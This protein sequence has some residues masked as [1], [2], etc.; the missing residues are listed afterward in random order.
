[1]QRYPSA[2]SSMTASGGVQ[3]CVCRLMIALW[4]IQLGLPFTPHPLSPSPEGEG[5]G[6][7][8]K[9]K[10][11]LPTP[12]STL[13]EGGWGGEV[14][15]AG[16]GLPVLLAVAL[17][18]A[19][20]ADATITASSIG[21]R[22]TP[23]FNTGTASTNAT[24]DTVTFIGTIP[25][26]VGEG[27]SVIIG[28]G[29]ALV[30]KPVSTTKIKLQP[31]GTIGTNLS[32]QAF[33]IKRAQGS[34]AQWINLC[35]ANLV[36]ATKIW[37]AVYYR[38]QPTYDDSVKIMGKTTSAQY[39]VWI[40]AAPQARHTGKANTGVRIVK[41]NTGTTGIILNNA[42][43][44]RIEWLELARTQITAPVIV[45]DS[46]APQDSVVLSNLIIEGGQTGIKIFSTTSK[47]IMYNI[48]GYGAQ[49]EIVYTSSNTAASVLYNS[50]LF[51]NNSGYC[52]SGVKAV[53]VLA[54]STWNQCFTLPVAGSGNNIS[55]DGT[56]PGSFSKTNVQFPMLNF[57]DT[58]T[59]NRDL[60]IRNGSVAIN[61]GTDLSVLFMHDIEG[62]PRAGA[63]DIGADEYPY[64]M[65]F[66]P[67]THTY[68]IGTLADINVTVSSVTGSGPWTVSFS[69]SPSLSRI[70]PGDRFSDGSIHQAVWT[71]TAVDDG[72]D[73]ITVTNSS[74]DT[75]NYPSPF[76]GNLGQ[77]RVGRWFQKINDWA[78]SRSGDLVTGQ[79][80]EKGVCYN[81]GIMD[82]TLHLAGSTTNASYHFWL[83]TAPG[84]RHNGIAG[85]GF[86]VRPTCTLPAN[87]AI[88]TSEVA[89]T[90]IENL[91]VDGSGI[92][93]GSSVNMIKILTSSEGCIVR[94]NL[95]HSFSAGVT[96]PSAG[97]YLGGVGN[98]VYAYNN[99]VRDLDTWAAVPYISG[100][101]GTYKFVFNNTALNLSN[102]GSVAYNMNGADSC[103]NNIAANYS[104]TGF[105]N[106]GGGYVGYNISTDGS[107][108]G[109]NSLTGRTPPSLFMA[110]TFDAHLNGNSPA[111]NAGTNLSGYFTRDIDDTL[112]QYGA[113]DVG[114]DEYV[115]G[116]TYWTNTGGDFSW[117]NPL[118]WST[119]FVPG[120]HDTTVFDNAHSSANCSVDQDVTVAKLILSN[121]YNGNFD[122]GTWN[123]SVTAGIDIRSNAGVAA[124]NATLKFITSDGQNF[125][126][127]TGVQFA[128][129]YTE[130]GGGFQVMANGFSAGSLY[131]NSG[132]ISLGSG[133]V[134]SIGGFSASA[135]TS[136][137]FES[138]T[139]K[140]GGATLDLNSVDDVFPQTGILEFKNISPATFTPK[141]NAN[142]VIVVNTG[143]AMV[144]VAN[145]P[146]NTPKIIV[147]NGTLHLDTAFIADSVFVQAGATFEQG[148]GNYSDT[149]KSIEG[150]G[151]VDMGFADFNVTGNLDL[152]GFNSFIGSG[153]IRFVGA[154]AQN[155]VPKANTMYPAI[156]QDGSGGTTVI[157]NGLHTQGL[158]I[159][160]GAFNIG[161]ALVDSV[162]STLTGAGGGTLDFGTSVLRTAA[163]SVDLSAIG[164][165]SGSSGSIEFVGGGTQ[166]FTAKEGQMN[167]GLAAFYG[168]TL[169]IANKHLR[170]KKVSAYGSWLEFDTTT[171]VDTVYLDNS[172]SITFGTSSTKNDTVK[173]ITGTG[174]L[175]FG[176]GHV[177][178]AGDM[179]DLTP[180]TNVM[181]LGSLRMRGGLSQVIKPN[182][183][184]ALDSVIID[185]AGGVTVET[186][187]LKCNSL[188]LLTGA[189]N[190][191][192]GLTDSVG[193]F[194]SAVAGSELD[195]NSATLKTAAPTLD[196]SALDVLVAGTGT[197]EFCGT[198]QGFIPKDGP[199]HPGII[200][201]NGS[202]VTCSTNAL[203][204]KNLNVSSGNFVFYG[205]GLTHAFDTLTGTASGSLDF[206]GANVA[207]KGDANFGSL[208][209]IFGS[210]NTDTL[211]FIRTSGTQ[212]LTP[213][214]SG[215]LPCIVHANAGTLKLLANN[216]STYG[217]LN[218]GGP[219]DIGTSN[220][221]STG[222]LSIL[223]GSPTLLS[224]I[225]G[226]TLSANN[227][228]TLSGTPGNL[229]NLNPTSTWYAT[230]T[231]G[232]LNAS[233]ATIGYSDA[234]GGSRGAAVTACTNDGNNTHWGIATTVTSPSGS[235]NT[236][237]NP[238]KVTG[239]YTA[240]TTPSD[241]EVRL[242]NGTGYWNGTDWSGNS[243]SW[244]SLTPYGSFSTNNWEMNS[245]VPAWQN[246]T[247][248]TVTSR[249]IEG[250]YVETP[251]AGATFDYTGPTATLTSPTGLQGTGPS[252]ISGTYTGNATDVEVE[253]YN[254]SQYYT[255]G[256]W[257]A[258]TWLSASGNGSVTGY[259][260]NMNAGLPTWISG[261]TY[262]IRCRAKDNGFVEAVPDSDGFVYDAT[263]PSVNAGTD[264]AHNAQFNLAGGSSDGNGIASNAWTKISGA[265]NVTFGDAAS[266]TSTCQM[267]ADDVYVLRLTSID[268]ASNS[269]FDEVQITWDAT[270]PS[271]GSGTEAAHNA[272]F[273]LAGTASD[274]GSG[275]ASTTWIKLSGTGNVTFGN[276][277]S[278]TSSCQMDADDIYV[279]QLSATD[280]AGN[281][282]TG[283]LQVTW[284]ATA[285]SVSSGSTSTYNAPFNLTG[286]ASDAGSGLASTTW[287]KLSGSGNVTFGN[288]A[289][290]TST[291]Q[292][293]ADGIYVLQLSA[294]D[295]AGNSA[296]STVQIT[297]DGAAPI[298]NAGAD[299]TYNALFGLT[300]A[301][302]DAGSGI[303]SNAW[304]KFS[305]PGTVTFG[306]AASLTSSCSMD[307]DGIY[308][309]RLTATDNSA[310][311]AND[312]VQITWDATAPSVSSG[313]NALHNAQ[314]NLAG[315]ATDAV[316]GLSSTTWSK[317]SGSGNVTFGNT[318][319]LTSTCQ[320]DADDIYVLQ[321]SATDVAGNTATSTLQ[322]TWDA[323]NPTGSAGADAPQSAL[324]NLSGSASDV[325][326]GI[327]ST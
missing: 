90:I 35:P 276:T 270:A 131:H 199:A 211:N 61:A 146:L 127:K 28:A 224:D 176:N 105:I 34:M 134:D 245:S 14:K 21:Q 88:I 315:T 99:I 3:K 230:V 213:P 115:Y 133:V 206:A 279:L 283:T 149:L 217:F 37:K 155:L 273:N 78:K 119:G 181:Q 280:V 130:N 156:E 306:N 247:N 40:T 69:G 126:G 299:G 327:A 160:S 114:A 59:G 150:A 139:L 17:F 41:N 190:L 208:A 185:N 223:N 198:S 58:A 240:A 31:G 187:G 170:A 79:R 60:R 222:S 33:T 106:S 63:F 74:Y 295:I 50:T 201:S 70:F 98:K 46:G 95:V 243:S 204:G 143:G 116:N 65:K 242:Y 77:A 13:R 235:I 271:V 236:Y 261:T 313:S 258:Q 42:P 136:L 86:H 298:V 87:G 274:A 2:L 234:S 140:F 278:T 255:G 296:S 218:D 256:G 62:M 67:G 151:S 173:S 112:R 108:S 5:A 44:T 124:T 260:W 301:S 123:F 164:T 138:A 194:F 183:G 144:T 250:G 64:F 81:D 55:N 249:S 319:S 92:T 225:S 159:T 253:I 209:N 200:V 20:E 107:A 322:V 264:A 212:N 48:I 93:A 323:T 203:Q 228:M 72:L 238:N 68:N 104:G 49:N 166:T 177:C 263:G 275:L 94:N 324:F 111:I 43:F 310:N 266:L 314:F 101:A 84:E 180:F 100:D 145:Q 191:G 52:A 268:N 15:G 311:P 246:G 83:T 30:E 244:L 24:A 129:I 289:S 23:L 57:V 321:L 117:A 320:M 302:S 248:Y 318:A 292:M 147:Q 254:G 308:V 121:T 12:P 122:F 291:C 51:K 66:K 325:T 189:L 162:G 45:P 262:N 285:P 175:D 202:M 215:T 294:N 4:I 82:D 26:S 19:K 120:L 305:G 148:T 109:V 80:L 221:T 207:V 184:W 287:S 25:D 297:W 142:P 259:A 38:D 36:T 174:S 103:Y 153:T 76:N 89:F 110:G 216:L 27:D 29:G 73:Q 9:T 135:G 233:Y 214:S 1:M 171:N 257:G 132:T 300:G 154:T 179:L 53:N 272:Q 237:P 178:F 210:G 197:L 85:T 47:I 192:V 158:T 169:N 241:I 317:L 167:P 219:L 10:Q 269:N 231:A 290:L 293:D 172:S 91:E 288:T 54:A 96:T 229:L 307:A 281:T 8:Q 97:I 252:A 195:F 205:T 309:L 312:D 165:V 152:T 22:T 11:S 316:S 226:R 75:I 161:A 137:E 232:N 16:L 186:N 303:S 56:A 251:G 220:I 265:G 227:G 239:T 282:A 7:A 39:Y 188:N 113:W 326:S 163:V 286:S 71:V 6:V 118:N 168:T 193:V 196:F 182:S 277:A 128:N 284:D 18:A 125:Y 157:T 304:T 267:D 102:A 141:S 32:G